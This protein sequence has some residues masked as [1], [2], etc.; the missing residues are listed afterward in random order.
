MAKP[1]TKED[2]ATK[3]GII[4]I[5]MGSSWY[6][7]TDEVKTAVQ[8]AKI[9]KADW[10]HMFKFERHHAFPVNIYDISKCEDGWT[11]THRGVFC[12]KTSQKMPY[13]KTIYTVV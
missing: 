5:G 8:C 2:K 13:V 6:Q 7:G 10:K 1:K 11:A 12:R 9:C 3:V 4:F